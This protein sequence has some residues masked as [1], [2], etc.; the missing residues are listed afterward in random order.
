MSLLSI[1]EIAGSALSAQSQRMNVSASNMANADS[2]AGPDGQPYR[3][4]QVVFQVNPPAGQAFGQ[5]IG[6]VRVVGVVEDQSP[7]KKI[8]DPKHPMA[9]AQG[10]VNMPNVDP[11]AETVN[12]IAASRSYQANVEVLNTAKQLMLKTLTIGQS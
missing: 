2:V 4:R 10:Y 5:E 9:D 12:M 6:G 8:Y 1:F 3:A 11:V 7:F